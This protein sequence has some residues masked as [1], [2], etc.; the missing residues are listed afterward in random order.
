MNTRSLV[1]IVDDLPV[2][3]ET[4]AA[5]LAKEPYDLAFAN[6]GIE[7]L[8][9][10][11]RLTPDV[12]LL[13]VMMPGIDGYEVCRRLRSD[14][15][16]SE[17]PIVMLT[18]LDDRDSRLQGIEAGA[19]DF[20]SKPF[21][22]VE[23]RAR[24]RT[25]LRLNRYRRLLAER[26][27]NDWVVERA[28]VGYAVVDA[29]DCVVYA[30]PLARL[31]LG[32]PPVETD[33]TPCKFWE[34]ITRQYRAEP[35][36]AWNGWPDWEALKPDQPRYLVRPETSTSRPFWL[37]VS[38]LDQSLGS[39][40]RHLICLRNV[41]D[42]MSSNRERATF[43]AMMMHKVRT[44]LTLVRGGA[45]LLG[46][47]CL[48]DP[49]KRETVEMLLQGVERLCAAVNDIWR[50][51]KAAPQ[52]AERRGSFPLADLASLLSG[53]TE[54]LG[55]AAINL[56][57]P[58]ELRGG[59]VRLSK[60]AMEWVLWELLE[61]AVKFHPQ[62]APVVDV[63]V[64]SAHPDAITLRVQ[65]D[66]LTLSPEQIA[67]AWVPYYQGERYLTGNVAGMGLGLPLVA[68]LVWEIGGQC[69]LANREDGP[70]VVVELQL[71]FSTTP[72]ADDSVG[73]ARLIS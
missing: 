37:R 45:E 7:A 28:D 25:I 10:A 34:L 44:P 41:T 53:L 15:R 67:N 50:Y 66:G 63:L 65:D 62:Q 19:D 68:S 2:A 14:P 35:Q 13:D 71:P 72:V 36:E 42:E 38:T 4:M 16:L 12:I 47:A 22:R 39:E 27:G 8:E 49:D 43:Q 31:Y 73:V 48:S 23:L 1:L 5:L 29:G 51:M 52:A 69:R 46:E 59:A 9:K 26:A 40:A 33:A 30:N 32:L 17:V 18:A 11:G 54:G 20:I 6:N 64:I 56:T 70:G 57:L 58:H 24:L 55:L 21:D 60:T 3:C 61:N